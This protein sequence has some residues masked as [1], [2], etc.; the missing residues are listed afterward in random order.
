M[1]SQVFMVLVVVVLA[2]LEDARRTASSGTVVGN[3]SVS[4]GMVHNNFSAP[5]LCVLPVLLQVQDMP[6]TR[7]YDNTIAAALAV[8]NN[9]KLAPE[10]IKLPVNLPT[11]SVLVQD[12]QWSRAYANTFAV[13]LPI[14]SEHQPIHALAPGAVALPLDLS[15]PEDFSSASFKAQTTTCQ[16][17]LLEDACPDQQQALAALWAHLATCPGPVQDTLEMLKPQDSVCHANW[18]TPASHEEHPDAKEGQAMCPA[19]YFLGANTTTAQAL[20]TSASTV[21]TGNIRKVSKAERVCAAALWT[22]VGILAFTLARRHLCQPS[23]PKENE[24]EPTPAPASSPCVAPEQSATESSP[25]IESKPHDQPP[26]SPMP[27]PDTEDLSH[28]WQRPAEPLDCACRSQRFQP[29]RNKR[30]Q[31]QT[32]YLL[33][34]DEIDVPPEL[35]AQELKRLRA[36]NRHQPAQPAQLPS[37]G[38]HDF[39]FSRPA[40]SSPKLLTFGYV[41]PP[42]MTEFSFQCPRPAP[43]GG[44]A[45]PL[46]GK[47]L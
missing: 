14:E 32:Y 5:S 28:H 4:A 40:P 35:V 39:T 38:K 29:R 3:P 25:S 47:S 31:I 8:N 2:Y 26:V 27:T 18:T 33:P 42:K 16:A 45:M 34:D 15:F 24:C 12:K 20:K 1:A 21:Y 19:A 46:F 13:V 22:L 17:S 10:A 30:R 41:N 11:T 43:T 7:P 44:A 9:A 23:A 6:W 37:P 36:T